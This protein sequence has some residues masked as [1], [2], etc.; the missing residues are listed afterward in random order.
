MTRH[1]S[2]TPYL[3][4]TASENM[5]RTWGN[6]AISIYVPFKS[7]LASIS[8]RKVNNI[9]VSILPI[10]QRNWRFVQ[11]MVQIS[12]YHPFIFVILTRY[13]RPQSTNEGQVQTPGFAFPPRRN[14]YSD[15]FAGRTF[16]GR[17]LRSLALV[18]V[19]SIWNMSIIMSNH[20]D[21]AWFFIWLFK[22]D[23]Q[24]SAEFSGVVGNYTYH[25]RQ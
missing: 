17:L 13:E 20:Q 22:I 19:R 21:W 10:V 5:R 16:S 7:F 24:L 12:M 11:A 2:L 23:P 4:I 1:H 15:K 9:Y 18:F 6:Q 8:M 3:Q 14:T 25:E